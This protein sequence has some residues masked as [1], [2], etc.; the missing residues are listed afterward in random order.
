MKLESFNKIILTANPSFASVIEA[1]FWNKFNLNLIENGWTLIHASARKIP[2][3]ENTFIIPARLLDV[4]KFFPNLNDQDFITPSWI[5]DAILDLYVEWEHKR[6]QILKYDSNIK[7]GLLKL[8]KYIDCVFKILKPAICLTTNKIDH[9]TLFFRMAAIYYGAKAYVIE[10]SPFDSLWIEKEGIFA[11]SAI[12]Y[13]YLNSQASCKS[14]YVTNGQKVKQRLIENPE[15]FRPQNYSE[16]NT[17]NAVRKLKKPIFFLPM[18]NI[19]WTGWAQ[20]NHPQ[21]LIDYPLYETP[22]EALRH[23]NECVKKLGGTLIVKKHPACVEIDEKNC[24]DIIFIEGKLNALFESSDVVICFNTKLAFNALA[25]EKPV[26]TLSPNPIIASDSTYHTYNRDEVLTTLSVALKREAFEPKYNRFLNFIGWA[27]LKYFIKSQDLPDFTRRSQF[28]LLSELEIEVENMPIQYS[29]DGYKKEIDQLREFLDKRKEWPE[30]N[31]IQ[32]D[33]CVY[34]DVSRLLLSNLRRSGISR[35]I[36]EILKQFSYDLNINIIP[37]ISKP[38][39]IEETTDNYLKNLCISLI[40]KEPVI[41]EENVFKDKNNFSIYFSPYNPLPSIIPKNIV[42]AIYLHDV[43]HI[44]NV[45]LYGDKNLLTNNIVQSIDCKRDYVLCNSEYTRKEIASLTNI[46]IERISVVPLAASPIFSEANKNNNTY[47]PIKILKNKHY[48]TIFAQFDPRK[49][50]DTLISVIDEFFLRHGNDDLLCVVIVSS[51]HEKKML[52]AIGTRIRSSKFIVL[53]GISDE[54]MVSVFKNSLFFVFTPLAEGF[55]LPV[56]EAMSVGCPVITS[57]TSSLPEVAGDAALYVNPEAPETIFDGIN[58]MVNNNSL[59]EEL[60]KK[61]LKN[62]KKFSWSKSYA[63]LR[64]KLHDFS[65]ANVIN[66]TKCFSYNNYHNLSTQQFNIS[67]FTNNNG[68]VVLGNGPSLRKIKLSNIYLP[69]IGMNNAYRYWHQIGWYPTYYMCLDTVVTESHEKDIERL[70]QDSEHNGIH[71]FLV[72]KTLVNRFHHLN[73][74][75]K[76]IVF[77]DYLESKYFAGINLTTGSFAPLFGAMLGY[78]QIYLLGIDLN[79]VQQ[80]P[81]ARKINS[82]VLEIAQTPRNN[83]NYFFDDYQ[84]KGDRYNIPDSLPDLHYQS[85]VQVKCRLDE[86]GVDVLNGNPQSRIANLFDLMTVDAF[87]G[88]KSVQGNN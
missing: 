54:D 59:R 42:R 32:K 71:L 10:R 14:L 60:A 11:E 15:G 64:N 7:N 79:Y 16:K 18:D 57:A 63:T 1:E 76:V 85:W 53:A 20:I 41:L 67:L 74:N 46:N 84:R 77:D 23:I 61:S 70:I 21:R 73:H 31:Q 55:G 9:G 45:G 81:E 56:L 69:T 49:N 37:V 39:W 26:V 35:F 22:Y 78:R 50:I 3:S 58:L 82:H 80:I 65:R 34:F 66:N 87:L 83:P 4:N 27:D 25:F 86:L 47:S 88:S 40:G 2:S 29:S 33:L 6:W 36:H 28:S 75:P 68:I 17:L 19:L 12:F 43:I 48:F 51:A 24:D 72:R 5:N 44:R 38:E 52:E 8:V 13:S 62:S 30:E